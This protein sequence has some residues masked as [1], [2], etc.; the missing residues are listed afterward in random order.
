MSYFWLLAIVL[1]GIALTP[2]VRPFIRQRDK[3][4]S[5]FTKTGDVAIYRD[6]LDE[7]ERD[8]TAGMISEKE[9]EVARAEIGRRLIEAEATT[10]KAEFYFD[11][12][13]TAG[14][15]VLTLAIGAVILYALQG[16]PLLQSRPF[17]ATS[18]SADPTGEVAKFSEKLEKKLR[19]NPD[20]L[21]G[22]TR[23]GEAY[24]LLG[25]YPEASEAYAHAVGLAGTERPDLLA[26]YAE[27]L[28]LA[29]S[30]KVTKE[31]KRAFAS[32]LDYDPKDLSARYYLGLADIQEENYTAGLKRWK[33][34][35]KDL[36]KDHVLLAPLR[37]QI[38]QLEEQ[39]R[40][41]KTSDGPELP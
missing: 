32:V 26:I 11:P 15:I 10:T 20:D 5:L 8:L 7:L 12:L 6:Q 36:P 33:A 27:T 23:L 17:D 9:A 35:A 2:L 39:I 22:W 28:V 21:E 3:I 34:L 24:R 4:E 19:D 31:A 37:T 30:G 18:A 38:K 13:R 41:K 16:S 29:E 40:S 25:R 1:T 14:V